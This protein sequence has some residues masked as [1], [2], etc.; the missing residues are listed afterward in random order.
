MSAAPT[1]TLTGTLLD[2]ERQSGTFTP[3]GET[4][5]KSFD[6]TALHVLVGREVVKVRLPKGVHVHPFSQGD[7]IEV[8]AEFPTRTRFVV[9]LDS[10][11]LSD[12]RASA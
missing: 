12:T 9:T 5:Q 6:F 11:G 10:I 1:V 8:E 4:E 7:V 3:D 2:T